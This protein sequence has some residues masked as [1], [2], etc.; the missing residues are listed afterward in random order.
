MEIY[1]HIKLFFFRNV[2]REN[3]KYANL[4]G[5]ARIYCLVKSCNNISN[6]TS[7]DIQ[8]TRLQVPRFPRC[9]VFERTGKF[10]KSYVRPVAIYILHTH[11]P[12]D[13][14]PAETFLHKNSHSRYFYDISFLTWDLSRFIDETSCLCTTHLVSPQRKARKRQAS[15]YLLV[16]MM[17]RDA[18]VIE[19]TIS[20]TNIK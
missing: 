9:D 2:N 6:I 8:T 16:R 7:D 5:F 12:H 13:G 4:L 15:H 17:Q 19:I 11:L 1:I 14:N 10:T 20:N 18:L 3:I